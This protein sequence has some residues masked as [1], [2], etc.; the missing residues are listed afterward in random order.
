MNYEKKNEMKFQRGANIFFTPLGFFQMLRY[1]HPWVLSLCFGQCVTFTKKAIGVL[2]F[3]EECKTQVMNLGN[4]LMFHKTQTD[5][6]LVNSDD[7]LSK[8]TFSQ[9]MSECLSYKSIN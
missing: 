8:V 5:F 6:H 1:I 4:D 3:G 7:L 9:I 2:A